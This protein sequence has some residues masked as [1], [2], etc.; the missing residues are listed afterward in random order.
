MPNNH[1]TAKSRAMD[2]F[3]I[4]QAPN[5]HP[6]RCRCGTFLSPG[7]KCWVVKGASPALQPLVEGIGFCSLG[8]LRVFLLESLELFDALDRLNANLVVDDLHD[9]YRELSHLLARSIESNNL[10]TPEGR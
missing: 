1:S 3:E 9:A 8:C 10:R 6:Q 2:S 5:D 4:L 7:T